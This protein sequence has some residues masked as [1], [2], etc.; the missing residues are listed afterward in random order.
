MELK[1]IS[2]ASIP[3]AITRAKHYR[4]LN[5]PWQA[6]SICRDILKVDPTNQLAIMHLI[7]A[8]TDQF[9]VQKS[10]S[11]SEAKSLC[12]KF[13]SEYEQKYY[14]GIIEERLGKTALKRSTPRVRYIAYDHYRKAMQFFEEAEK[15]SPEGNQDSVLRWNACVRRIEE[16]KLEPSPEDT[17][18]QPFL[19]I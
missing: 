2:T 13:E 14:R 9:S 6:E 7:L 1:P 17:G 3:K 10:K 16:Y 18:V 8:I 5:E 11:S 12:Q 19:D 4:L 15:I